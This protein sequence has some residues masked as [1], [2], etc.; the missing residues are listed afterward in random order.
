[1]GIYAAI[2]F[3]LA[4]AQVQ[5]MEINSH[6]WMMQVRKILGA[7]FA[8]VALSTLATALTLYSPLFMDQTMKVA[9]P[10]LLTH[11]LWLIFCQHWC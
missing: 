5:R 1:M 2:W 9:G 3:T 10:P 8:A 7:L 6:S 11:W 4:L